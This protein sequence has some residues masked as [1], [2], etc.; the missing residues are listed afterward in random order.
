MKT[1]RFE[2]PDTTGS[3]GAK[4]AE[5][6]GPAEFFDLTGLLVR[7]MQFAWHHGYLSVRRFYRD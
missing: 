2:F 4:I 3:S 7:T 5:F 6:L 1:G